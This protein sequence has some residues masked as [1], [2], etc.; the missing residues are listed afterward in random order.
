MRMAGI[1][2]GD[3]TWTDSVVATYIERYPLMDERGQAPYTWDTATEP[4]TQD[5]NDN[6]I[7]SYDLNAAAADVLQERATALAT[8]FDFSADG[9]SYQRSQQYEAL[10]AQCRYYRARRRPTS[11]TAVKWPDERQAIPTVWIG[12]LPEPRI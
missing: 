8:A 7:P 12:N 4:P 1:A 3:T 9:A 10:M 6:W 5:A 2:A 11:M